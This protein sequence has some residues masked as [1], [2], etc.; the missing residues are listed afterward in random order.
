M[1]FLFRLAPP[2]PR[3]STAIYSLARAPPCPQPDPRGPADPT[4]TSHSWLLSPPGLLASV[5]VFPRL[6]SP[7]PLPAQLTSFTGIPWRLE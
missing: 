1:A 5:R 3:D 6:L 4:S 7:Q 2:S